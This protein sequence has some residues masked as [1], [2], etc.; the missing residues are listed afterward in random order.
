MAAGAVVNSLDAMFKGN[1]DERCG[2]VFAAVR[3][4]GHHAHMEKSAGFCI[5][6]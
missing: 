3:P 4:P 6:N 5:F 2:T 1:S